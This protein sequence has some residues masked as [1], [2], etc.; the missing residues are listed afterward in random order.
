M[1]TKTKKEH[2]ATQQAEQLIAKREAHE[3]T[4]KAHEGQRQ[5]LYQRY[6]R[7]LD[8]LKPKREKTKL[9]QRKK[10]EQKDGHDDI[11]TSLALGFLELHTPE[12]R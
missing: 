1:T 5:K 7:M 3:A 2:K 11:E 6:R 12:T 4:V 8:D 9:D 10:P